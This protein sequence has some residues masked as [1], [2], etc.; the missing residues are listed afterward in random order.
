MTAIP[1][2]T[3]RAV[4]P[5][6]LDYATACALKMSHSIN[7]R[8]SPSLNIDKS[9]S[10]KHAHVIDKWRTE[11]TLINAVDLV[12]ESI[13]FKEYD[14]KDA[15]D[16]AKYILTNSPAMYSTQK[17]LAQ[18]LLQATESPLQQNN[19]AINPAL[20]G[21]NLKIIRQGLSIYPTNA[22]AWSDLSIMYAGSGNIKKAKRAATVALAL[23]GNNRLILR[24]SAHCYL[25]FKEPDRAVDLL[26][27]SAI[28]I[29]DPWIIAAE[30]AI[31]ES[32]GFKSRLVRTARAIVVDDN[33]T[34]FSRSE[35][36]AQ[37]G[38]LE[39]KNASTR[40]AKRLMKFSIEDGTENALAQV[41]WFAKD[42]R[43]EIERS[44][45]PILAPFEAEF[46]RLYYSRNYVQA[47]EAAKLWSRFQPLSIN[48]MLNVSA[49]ACTQLN[50]HR[51]FLEFVDQALPIVRQ[52][53]VIKNDYAVSLLELGLVAQAKQVLEGIN[54]S[55][56]DPKEKY[57]HV[58]TL[59][60]MAFK[61]QQY[62]VGGQ[63]YR[64]SIDGFERLNDKIYAAI[65][66]FY[67]AREEQRIKSE[68]AATLVKDAKQRMEHIGL[69]VL[70]DLLK[71]L[72]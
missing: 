2:D 9:S 24:N 70:L 49:L 11:P 43:V 66:A 26:R 3:K 39:Y 23:G 35:L 60:L 13:I 58:A 65:A 61:L 16:A 47:L 56:L 53:P 63:F 6:W 34:R 19:T 4:I 52:D 54:V 17:D 5:R 67:W 1:D 62:S 68:N 33:L 50:Y 57:V 59:G 14:S 40:H 12:S 41:Q 29:I 30:M 42:A 48:P 72:N 21:N 64:S 25:H 10:E 55:L 38:T 37:L 18:Y 51:E 20:N 22:L 32:A 71:Q 28:G 15:Q 7:T 36:A 27:K 69:N 8:I 46:W 44:T 31:S 45:T